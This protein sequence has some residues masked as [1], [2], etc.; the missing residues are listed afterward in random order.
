[1]NKFATCFCH[2]PGFFSLLH[3]PLWT[4]TTTRFYVILSRDLTLYSKRHADSEIVI[5]VPQLPS[6]TKRVEVRGDGMEQGLLKQIEKMN[7]RTQ[8][9]VFYTAYSKVRLFYLS[10]IF[11][12]PLPNFDVLQYLVVKYDSFAISH[13]SLGIVDILGITNNNSHDFV[14]SN[15]FK[16]LA[17]HTTA[18]PREYKSK[19]KDALKHGQAISASINLFTLRSLARAK[20]DDKFFTHW[21]PCKDERG[22]VAYAVVTLSSTLYE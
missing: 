21:T 12:S 6:S 14:G 11:V 19:V 10:H 3:P 13:Y 5:S 8:M 1:M 9:E 15:I 16:F 17:Q 4:V 18:L 22:S 2:E 20:G 7:F